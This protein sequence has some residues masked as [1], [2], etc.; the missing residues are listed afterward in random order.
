[1]PFKSV[2]QI[3]A[4]YNKNQKNWNCDEYLKHTPSVCCLPNKKGGSAK[5]CVKVKRRKVNPGKIMT[6][7]RG[8]KYFII[9]EKLANGKKCEKKI[10]MRR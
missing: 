2:A 5:K 9:Y 8:G 4:C 3:S 10:Y 1:M 7:P 6:G